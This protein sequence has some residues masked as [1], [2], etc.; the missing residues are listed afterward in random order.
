MNDNYKEEQDD[1]KEEQEFSQLKSPPALFC[2][3]SD[4]DN[5]NDDDAPIASLE[6]LVPAC[7]T[8]LSRVSKPDFSQQSL[9][10]DIVEHFEKSN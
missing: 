7:R 5:I 9:L 6:K 3:C 1:C 10:L 4:D 2:D 8:Q